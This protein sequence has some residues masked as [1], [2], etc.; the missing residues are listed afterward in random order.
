MPR[1]SAPPNKPIPAPRLPE[2]TTR[3]RFRD[4]AAEHLWAIATETPVEI[5]FNGTAWTVM[6]ATPED[7]EDMARGIAFSEGAITDPTAITAIT[8][9]PYAEGIAIDIT[10]PENALNRNVLTRR[11]ME[12][13]TGC[14]LCGVERLADLAR[15]AGQLPAPP[16]GIDASQLTK[17][18]KALDAALPL[19]RQTRSVH[20]AAWLAADGTLTVV[21]EDVGR[22]N[23]LDK[24]IG[25]LLKD[26]TDPAAGAILMTSRCSFELVQKTARFGC[27]VLA[28]LSAP[29]SLALSLAAECGLTLFARGPEG[30]ALIHQPEP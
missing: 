13:R 26:G 3:A 27:P 11:S 30:N 28:T 12:G 19:S 18:F 5:G 17:G 20:G 21:R 29:T 24:L 10:I 4:G 7:L 9:T 1:S 14:G 8:V 15:P 16:S 22:H 2:A 25:A 6:L 23:A